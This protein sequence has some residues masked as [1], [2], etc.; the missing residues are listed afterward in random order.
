LTQ[1]QQSPG[2]QGKSGKN[3]EHKKFWHV[4]FLL[5]QNCR[6]RALIFCSRAAGKVSRNAQGEQ[7]KELSC[8]W[9]NTSAAGML[10]RRAG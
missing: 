4:G 9:R 2:N 1:L 5:G 7:I 10:A 3:Q 8:G 6:M